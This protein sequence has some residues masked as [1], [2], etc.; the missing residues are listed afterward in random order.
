MRALSG[1][2]MLGKKDEATSTRTARVYL[3]SAPPQRLRAGTLAKEVPRALIPILAPDGPA[4][5]RG[6]HC[7]SGG[8]RKGDGK[9]SGGS[10]PSPP[11]SG[12]GGLCS[13]RRRRADTCEASGLGKGGLGRVESLWC[14]LQL[15]ALGRGA[16]TETEQ[17]VASSPGRLQGAV[18]CGLTVLLASKRTSPPPAQSRISKFAVLH[19]PWLARGSEGGG[20]AGHRGSLRLAAPQPQGGRLE[21]KVGSGTPWGPSPAGL[22]EQAGLATY[23]QSRSGVPYD[24]HQPEQHSR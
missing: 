17:A 9:G 11:P 23:L 4:P 1:R 3:N 24:A 20:M 10:F 8:K 22:G 15:C 13:L 16:P 7:G 12:T 19:T 5:S 6:S 2:R 14:P 18:Q 21:Q